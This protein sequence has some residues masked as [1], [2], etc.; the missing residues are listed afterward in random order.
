MFGKK[1]NAQSLMDR[2]GTVAWATVLVAKEKWSS[3]SSNFSGEVKDTEHMHVELRVEPDGEQPFEAKFGQAFAG[4]MPFAGGLCKVV[5]DPADHSQIAVIDGSTAPPGLSREQAE[6]SSTRRADAREAVR[7]GNMAEYIQGMK[8]KA[9]RGELGGTVI[10]GGQ[11]IPQAGTPPFGAPAAPAE[12]VADQLTKLANLKDS[13]A[14]TDAEF[15][16]MKAK[17]L[18]SA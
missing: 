12:S 9:M 7:T 15:A 14:L 3:R 10:M 16:E 5:Y 6:A 18:G 13:G 8:D 17:L 4:G 2:G 1:T 11:M